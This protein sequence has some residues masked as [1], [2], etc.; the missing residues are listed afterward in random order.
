MSR[1]ESKSNFGDIGFF[2]GIRTACAKTSEFSD[3]FVIYRNDFLKL[4]SKFPKD[5]EKFNFIKDSLALYK[6]YSVINLCCYICQTES[7][8]ATECPVL[9]AIGDRTSSIYQLYTIYK[10]FNKNYNRRLIRR[11]NFRRT[12]KECNESVRK[13]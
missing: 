13:I 3:L 4:I 6:D 12:L 5:K 11:K 10:N 2:T 7:H 1:I 9:T 8:I